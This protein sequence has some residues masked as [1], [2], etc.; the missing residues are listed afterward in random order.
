MVDASRMSKP[1]L[2]DDTVLSNLALVGQMDL[3]FRL[4]PERICTTEDVMREYQV[5]VQ[6][7]ILQ[8]TLDRIPHCKIN[9]ERMGN[10]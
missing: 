5:A 2:L 10:G 6:N 4:W 9:S 3:V 7:G 1:I 8:A